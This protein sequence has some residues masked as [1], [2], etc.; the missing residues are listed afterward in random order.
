VPAV[1]GSRRDEGWQRLIGIAGVIAGLS[2]LLAALSGF[3]GLPANKAIATFF[4]VL[5]IFFGLSILGKG[6]HWRRSATVSLTLVLGLLGVAALGYGP[7]WVLASP[8]PNPPAGPITGPVVPV[9]PCPPPAPH[10]VFTR[11][12][13]SD[14]SPVDGCVT[15][16]WRGDPPV[17]WAY[18]AG[19]RAPG[20]DLTYYEG[21]VQK[22]P[23]GDWSVTLT[24]GE[25]G[26][27][28]G[29][30]YQI[31]IIM[32]PKDLHDYLQASQGDDTVTYWVGSGD[33]PGSERV[34]HLT[35]TRN[36]NPARGGNC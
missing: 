4:F 2:G 34:D 3:V 31:A 20:D 24:L 13:E 14:R 5:A 7:W 17:G 16:T 22:T 36:N 32:L 29:Q 27:G 30:S 26:K 18:A 23:A 33:P 28:M 9:A 6:G 35:V 10:L 15:I 8:V 11:P 25:D 12:L 21:Q 19:S 1:V